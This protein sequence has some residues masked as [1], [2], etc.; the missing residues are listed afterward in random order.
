MT[1]IT[2]VSCQNHDN[3]SIFEDKSISN[4]FDLYNKLHE[5]KIQVF[6]IQLFLHENRSNAWKIKKKYEELF[7]EDKAAFYYEPPY[8]K[9]SSELFLKRSD[10][11]RKKDSLKDNFPDCF[12]IRENVNLKDY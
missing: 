11:E 3:I 7:P 1:F 4:F 6:K 12:I 2:N 5:K 10:A 8:F 9:V